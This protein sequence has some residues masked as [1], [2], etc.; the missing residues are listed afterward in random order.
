MEL[1]AIL[2]AT[3]DPV[4]TSVAYIDIGT[5][6]VNAAAALANT[7]TA[8]PVGEIATPK[9][10]DL[11]SEDTPTIPIALAA[12]G[13]TY[14]LDYQAYGRDTWTTITTGDPA[15]DADVDGL[16]HLAWANPGLG[17]Y[18]LRLTVTQGA[19]SH[20]DTKMI[21]VQGGLQDSWPV[22]TSGY[23][24]SC[25]ICMDIDEDGHNEII[26]SSY[27]GYN[28]RTYIWNEDGTSLPGW[29]RF[30]Q[31]DPSC[32]TSA[33]GD[34]DGDGDYEIVTT[35][36]NGGYVY[37]WH[38]QD[39]AL[40]SGD[41]PKA[42]GY[43]IRSAPLLA[44][45][46]GDGDSEIIIAKAGHEDPYGV[47]AFQ[48]DGTMMWNYPVVNLQ[49]PMAAADL[50]SDGNIE[51]VAAGGADGHVIDHNGALVRTWPEGSFTAPVIADLDKD[52]QLEIITRYSILTGQEFHSF[53]R[54][55]H[56]DG[57]VL[58]ESELGPA[59][60]IGMSVGDLDGD[61]YQDVFV[62]VRQGPAMNYRVQA[63]DETG[64]P[65]SAWGLPKDTIDKTLQSAV[66]IGDIDGDGDKEALI[67]SGIGLLFGW[68]NSGSELGAFPRLIDSGFATTPTLADLDQDGDIEVMMGS[69]NRN[70]YVWDL[71]GAYDPDKIDWPMYRHD[72]QC[73]GLAL[74]VPKLAPLYVPPTV[75]VGQTLQLTL[76]AINPDGLSLDFYVRQMPD[77]AS[78]DPVTS[79]FTWTPTPDQLGQEFRFYLF[80]T[81]RIRQDHRP[82]SITV[83][84][85]AIPA[86][87]VWGL[88]AGTL[89]VATAGITALRRRRRPTTAGG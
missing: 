70:F 78:F 31:G 72:P 28:G 22:T 50:D 14:L 62:S 18:M 83:T 39:G 59:A 43:G 15:V 76:D 6:R 5:G 88:V 10:R 53:L 45:L 71:P 27:S 87:G 51:I 73:S 80:V 24:T 3:A 37:V 16:V 26:Q 57:S 58:W 67:G 35:T 65:L 19:H 86:T 47:Y 56:V 17:T 38:W 8:Y 79:T 12:H 21:G 82:V 7:A 54:T 60:G 52:S 61:T 55:M 69:Y 30:L 89:A 20:V 1:R 34:V 48:H 77:G 11:V 32:S 29:P 64:S 49:A 74:R 66:T 9:N 23:V 33:V 81:D 40:M 44:D 68:D 75:A 2:Q 85:T 25:A 63:Y 4:P 84:E 42:F 46:D 41:W 13:A 36:Y